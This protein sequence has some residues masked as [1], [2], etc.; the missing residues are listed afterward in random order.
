MKI[1]PSGYQYAQNIRIYSGGGTL[2][3]VPPP[4]A[5]SGP[6]TTGW[7]LGYPIGSGEAVAVDGGAVAY[8]AATGATMV[9]TML[10]GYTAGA[11]VPI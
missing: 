8:L 9:V 11:T 7:G 6:G 3:I 1:N 2:E 10:I 4:T 5:L